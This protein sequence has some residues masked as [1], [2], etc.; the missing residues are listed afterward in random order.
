MTPDNV[1]LEKIKVV[2]KS[3]AARLTVLSAIVAIVLSEIADSEF[4]DSLGP[5]V[6][7]GG[8]LLS[9]LA[10]GIVVLR[11]VTPVLD[12]QVGILTPAEA[13]KTVPLT[14]PVEPPK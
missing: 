6:K 1:T 3:L 9:A 2:V 7:W 10:L 14:G 5:V 12:S 13:P 11:R 8:S 4:S